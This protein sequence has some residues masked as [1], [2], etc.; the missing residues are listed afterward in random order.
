MTS[1]RAVLDSLNVT[2]RQ[3]SRGGGSGTNDNSRGGTLLAQ[4]EDMNERSSNLA[5]RVADIRSAA[6]FHTVLHGGLKTFSKLL[7][8]FQLGQ[9]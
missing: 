2:G 8:V 4:L 9:M 7:H 6:A 5:A 1:Q 3:M